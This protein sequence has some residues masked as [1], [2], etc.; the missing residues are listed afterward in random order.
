MKHYF[1]KYKYE[2]ISLLISFGIV[3]LYFSKVFK[4]PGHY[5]FGNNGDG[6]KNYF[7]LAYYVKNDKGFHFSGM[8]YPYGEHIAFTDNQP[9]LAL[10]LNF[11]DDNIVQISQHTIG[12]LNI[13]LLSSIAL[14]SFYTYKILRYFNVKQWLSVWGGLIIAFLSP[15]LERIGGHYA[16][17]YIFY[18]PVFWYFIITFHKRQR[19]WLAGITVFTIVVVE[20]LTHLYFLPICLLFYMAY[21]LFEVIFHRNDIRAYSHRELWRLTPMI[22]SALFVLILLKRTDTITDRPENPNGV[23]SYVTNFNSTFFPEKGIIHD[24]IQPGNQVWEGKA[25]VGLIGIVFLLLIFQHLFGKLYRERPSLLFNTVKNN[26][27]FWASTLAGFLTWMYAS[28]WLNTL[29]LI[30]IN[31]VIPPLKQFRSLGRFSWV[32]YYTFTVFMIVQINRWPLVDRPRLNIFLRYFTP[33]ILIFWSWEA[34]QNLYLNTKQIYHKNDKFFPGKEEKYSQILRAKSKS[35]NDYQAIL[36]LPNVLLGPEKLQIARGMWTLRES[37]AASY[38][39]GLPLINIMMSRTSV[40]QGLDYM[41]L[42]TPKFVRKSRLDHFS[43]KPILLLVEKE[44]L[45]KREKA[46]IRSFKPMHDEDGISLY[47]LG[48]SDFYSH[49][50]NAYLYP[51]TLS[52]A[53][54]ELTFDEKDSNIET[55]SGNGCQIIQE[56]PYTIYE[57]SLPLRTTYIF[58]FWLYMSSTTGDLSTIRHEWSDKG[59]KELKYQYDYHYPEVFCAQGNWLFIDLEFYNDAPQHHKFSV[60]DYPQIIDQ[61]LFRPVDIDYHNEELHLFNNYKIDK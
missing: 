5:L 21:V 10:L 1:L 45:S 42:F 54:I 22:L 59:S 19:K 8:N 16:L 9:I 58:S 11:I 26:N 53:I 61:V 25:Y 35:P 36:S 37:M 46:W 57:G 7:T 40:S 14:C 56:L 43:E 15:Q 30:Y 18:I 41:E 29:G 48:I 23:L 60:L 34:Y 38:Q 6:L 47:E 4:F 27:A 39:L 20:S 55:Y 31:E 52:S 12:L 51:D 17:G 13:L 3:F 32:F 28:G 24:L 2:L 33:V 50:L 49:D 44:H